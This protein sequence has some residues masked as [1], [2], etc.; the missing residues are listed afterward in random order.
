MDKILTIIIPTY[1]MSEYLDTCLKSLIIK[2]KLLEVLIINDGSKDNSLD[3]AK[4]YEKEYPHIFRT[5]DKPNGNYGS[6]VNRGLKEATG[7]YIKVLDADDKFNTESLMNLVEIASK[8]DVDAFITDFSKSHINGKEDYVTFDLPSNQ[9]LQFSDFCCHKDIINLWM[10]AITY[11]RENLLAINYKQTE[12]ISYTDQEWIFMPLTTIR[13]LMYV[14]GNLYIYTLGREGQTMSNTFSAKHFKDNL[15]CTSH[16][17]DS[18][19]TLANLNPA[20]KDMLIEKLFKRIRYIYKF[21]LLKCQ[22][23]DLRI[24]TELDKKLKIACPEVYERSNHIFMSSPLF[25]YKY[26]KHWRSNPNGKLL[27]FMIKLYRCKNL[28]KK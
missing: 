20:I 12:G 24:L 16:I 22:Q 8:T 25:L 17:L 9:T 11:K 5:I 4:K 2:S 18:Y 10:H 1:N 21:Y 6:C 13:T 26:I 19:A 28:S 7:K 27:Q 15:I 3:V 14:P 23:P